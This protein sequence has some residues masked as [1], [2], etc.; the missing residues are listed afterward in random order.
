M[1]RSSLSNPASY[2]HW[3]MSHVGEEQYL[4]ALLDPTRYEDIDTCVAALGFSQ[5]EFEALPT[6]MKIRPDAQDAWPPRLQ[7][8][9]AVPSVA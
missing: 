7:R 1:K 4:I 8:T 5:Q 2:Q 9:R 3:V 6:S